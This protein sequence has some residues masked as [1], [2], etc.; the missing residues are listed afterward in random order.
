MTHISN[1]TTYSLSH[2]ITTT[3]QAVKKVDA[4]QVVSIPPSTKAYLGLGNSLNQSNASGI[5]AKTAVF[6][7]TFGLGPS[8]VQVSS[9]V[10]AG[11]STTTASGATSGAGV[12]AF[13]SNYFT[14]KIGSPVVKSTTFNPK[15]TVTGAAFGGVLGVI[16][17]K[18]FDKNAPASVAEKLATSSTSQFNPPANLADYTFNLS[19]HAW[20]LPIAPSIVDTKSFDRYIDAP[21]NSQDK[22]SSYTRRNV[23]GRNPNTS[24]AA[25][26]RRGTITW[27]ATASDQT[28]S[29]SASKPTA[30][31]RQMGF[32]FLWNPDSFGTSV[33]LNPDVTPS[34][35]DRF[36]GVAGAF[37]G[38]ETIMLN[39][40]INRIN[41][42]A[43]FA[44][45]GPKQYNAVTKKDE[46]KKWKENFSKFYTP[47]KSGIVTPELMD[48][49]LL[50]LYENGT[51][52]DIEFL[53]QTINGPNAS[54]MSGGW[55]NSL[56]RVT[57]DIG[58]LSATL[59]RIEIGPLTYLG[60][61]NGISVNHIQFTQD[62]K[63]IRSQVQITANLMASVG[64][65]E[66]A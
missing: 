37:P 44:H 33:S 17:G 18:Y 61:I 64:L 15:A 35:Q 45:K 57:S 46:Q 34:M 43:C 1:G 24:P 41:D 9:T 2:P 20:S 53:Y 63:P 11:G 49:Q 22:G 32:Q 48:K 56:G 28:F 4:Q 36:V 55:K 50:D 7:P 13:G 8:V 52:H 42:F 51:L 10:A 25:P 39:L 62:M 27:H 30:D 21:G 38:Q 58:F 31:A 65:A 5:K 40:E 47:H 19:P 16:L 54:Y 14:S 66:G 60:Y 59:V 29:G 3:T 26:K 6:D 12:A 23:V